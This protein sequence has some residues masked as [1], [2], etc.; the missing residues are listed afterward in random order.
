MPLFLGSP[1]LR[2]IRS[3]PPP[4]PVGS[5]RLVVVASAGAQQQH[6]SQRRD[7]GHHD[8]AGEC[9]HSSDPPAGLLFTDSIRSYI[10]L[11]GI[12]DDGSSSRGR[13]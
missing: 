2:A 13:G 11:L 9:I 12:Y 3:D 5:R 6:C 1:S 7:A 10:N 4:S 8:E